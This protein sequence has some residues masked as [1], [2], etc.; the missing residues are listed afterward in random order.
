MKSLHNTRLSYAL[1]AAALAG[2][3][4][5]GAFA[6]PKY[7]PSADSPLDIPAVSMDSASDLLDAFAS[8]GK[9]QDA[10]PVGKT[11]RAPDLDGGV[12]PTPAEF[13]AAVNAAISA[14]GD[15]AFEI[16]AAAIQ[17]MPGKMGNIVFEI[18]KNNPT[19]AADAVRAGALVVPLKSA[20]AAGNAVKGLLL[21][22]NAND[23]DDL[24]AALGDAVH[25][26]SKGLM[27]AVAK[28]ALAGTKGTAL[29]VA[30]QGA[31]A[32]A[33]A[34]KMVDAAVALAE[35]TD[36]HLRIDDVARG[37]IA[38]VK[39]FIGAGASRAAI[40][41]GMLGR[42]DG[43]SLDNAR[44]V[45]N[46]VA[47]AFASSDV[48]GSDVFGTI[49]SV[50]DALHGESLVGVRYIEAIDTVAKFNAAIR[51][52]V[53]N[54]SRIA[55]FNTQLGASDA[56]HIYAAV[57]G[58]VQ[59]AKALAPDFVAAAYS[60]PDSGTLDLQAKKDVIAAAVTSNT[61]AQAKIVLK[62]VSL[63]G[64]NA[65]SAADAVAA[66]IPAGTELFAGSSLQGLVKLQTTSADAE[67]VLHAAIVA[68][69]NA[70]YQGALGDI[71]LGAAK[72][73]KLF[74]AQLIA[75][76][77]T[78]VS[79]GWEERVAAAIVA[80]DPANL[81][82]LAAAQGAATAKVGSALSDSVSLAIQ[83]AQ[84]AK[85]K[86][87]LATLISAKTIF[88]DAVRHMAENPSEARAAI[89]GAGAVEP[90]LAVPLLAAALRNLKDNETG[91]DAAELLAYATSLSKK[92]AAAT[93]VAFE[94]A[95]DA[96][97][98]VDNLTDMLDHKLLTNP[99]EALE[100][101]TAA[102]ASR[103]EYAHFVAR[104]AGFR[105][106]KVAGKLSAAIVEYAQMRK[107]DANNPAAIAAIS[108]GF[109]LGIKD[110]KQTAT[111]AKLIAA[112]VGGLIKG[113]RTFAQI[114]DPL[115][116]D[117]DIKS[118]LVGQTED[119][120]E[121]NGLAATVVGGTTPRRA[122][123]TA[124][125]VTG[126]V[127]ALQGLGATAD[128]VSVLSKAAITAAVKASKDH[129]LAIAQA[130][131]QACGFV[132]L[133]ENTEFTD[134]AGIVLAVEAAGIFSP[135]TLNAVQVGLAQVLANYPGAGAAGTGGTSIYAHRG[136]LSG[137]V[138]GP[139]TDISN[140]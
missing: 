98:S 48:T 90:G 120:A 114:N 19:K 76:A 45:A 80:N 14:D 94:T 78:D 73:N 135:G 25:A 41:A 54:P 69:N 24:A 61:D 32:A 93:Q 117:L 137:G 9:I 103:P 88:D 53:D 121:A 74:G 129:F 10:L 26:G 4:F 28:A 59:A 39:G 89:F 7:V 113:V 136:G 115:K 79:A 99:E 68:A 17:W 122:K 70:G 75:R 20:D 65:I 138:N 81:T 40:A 8:L 111:E 116:L 125:V 109:V 66:A 132:A 18:A 16:A 139:V 71:A 3:S 84:A 35:T 95:Q 42:L 31:R 100:I 128:V 105:G 2:L 13:F 36:A 96:L 1:V 130:A 72:G 37:A 34:N 50:R 62:A 33:V 46:F 22:A 134:A 131:A 21:A 85:G 112:A 57:S 44:D 106:F 67:A 12:A 15:Y 55:A 104:V 124:G 101:V 5:T 47:G 56:A 123:G 140:F 108:E 52:A 102:A 110:A 60:D 86:G 119:F 126:A 43:T 30:T 133:G 29:N 51:S 107:S 49:N 97:N 6:V 38:G 23:S 87:P 91:P 118:G 27:E 11:L 77:I 82:L 92:T 83:F 127:T 64:T 63:T 58:A